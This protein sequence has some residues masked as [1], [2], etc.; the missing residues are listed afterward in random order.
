MMKNKTTKILVNGAVLAAVAVIGVTAYQLSTPSRD[1]LV[2]K[3][4]KIEGENTGTEK[5][6]EEKTP[7]M[8]D[9]GTNQVEASMEETGSFKESATENKEEEKE[10][11]EMKTEESADVSTASA[12]ANI[13][14]LNFT[15]DTQMEWPVRGNILLDYSMD[16]TTYFPTLDQYR[17]SSG[18]SVQAVEGAPVMAAC[19][20]QVFSIEQDAKTGTT[21]TME[22]GNGYQSVYGQLTD[23]AVQKG[24]TVKKG[25]I[26]GYISAPTKYYSREGSNLYY[27]MKKN[28]EP[29]DPIL[30]LP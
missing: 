23:L 6:G 22:L 4:V 13:P 12:A 30:Y 8:V 11:Q 2:P 15:E 28:G 10:D 20:G 3:E 5:S 24:E 17:L 19:D 29:I 27:A 16:Q 14:T 7:S 26:I 9:A 25:A 21:V 1:E 18:I